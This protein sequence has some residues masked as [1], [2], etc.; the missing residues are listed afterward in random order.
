MQI[1]ENLWILTKTGIL[2]SKGHALENVP[3]QR[4][5]VTAGDVQNG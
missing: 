2:D 1:N 3:F 5:R 4:R